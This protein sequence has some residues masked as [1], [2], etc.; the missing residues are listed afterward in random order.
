MGSLLLSKVSKMLKAAHLSNT[1]NISGEELYTRI[2]EHTDMSRRKFLQGATAT[3]LLGTL[4]CTSHS[5]KFQ[6]PRSGGPRIGILGGGMAG[7]HCAYQL[8]KQGIVSKVFEASKRFGGRMYS[9]RGKFSDG[10]VAE[11]G[12]ELID[13]NHH[14]IRAL[15]V[16]LGVEIDDLFLN[17]PPGFR[18][19]AF[20]IHGAILSEE[21]IVHEFKPLAREISYAVRR[22]ESNE[23]RFEALNAMSIREWLFSLS[24]VS[25]FVKDIIE[26]A[27]VGEYGR[28]CEE[29]SVFNLL[30]L[31]DYENVSPFRIFGDSDER[32]HVHGGN[33]LL[34][35]KLTEHLDDSLYPD[36]RVV[37][38]RE[39]DDETFTVSFERK[40]GEI[41]SEDFDIVV[42]AIP[43]SVLREVE[44]K[45]DLPPLKK[46]IIKELGYG[47][48]TKIMAGFS[49][50][51]WNTRYNSSATLITDTALQTTWET[52]RGQNGK[53][54]II[55]NF[56]G[57]KRSL[58]AGQGTSDEQFLKG[59]PILEKIFSGVTKK[60]EEGSAIR[61][62]WPEA[63]Y[64]KG[65]YACYLVGQGGF[66]GYE[67]TRVRN[68]LF[69]GEHCSTDFQGF[70]EGACE[71]GA[72]AAADIVA[73]LA[74]H[75]NTGKEQLAA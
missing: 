36:S 38:I 11:L 48:N 35:S 34:I 45:M 72:G 15:A 64:V 17:E 18:R 68:L 6:T 28:E 19:E 75:G 44:F 42:S 51:V 13:S 12:G 2:E 32:F 58:D 16:E 62:H 56:L 54:A 23:Q 57:G 59:L 7:L 60:Y 8:K 3:A 41:F 5:V 22:A 21:R 55:T 49:E 71:T 30:Y 10:Q 50:R 53:S 74:L 70:M 46:K 4:G 43:F 67:G 61:M 37:S 27:Y 25:T 39:Q 47:Y 73:Q 20:Y 63:Q 65:S 40:G 26:A 14:T 24:N 1:L 69:C 33:D 29:Q 52:S 66:A 31:I 9:A